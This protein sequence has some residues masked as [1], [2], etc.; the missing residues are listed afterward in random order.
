MAQMS[1][2]QTP[3][4][5]GPQGDMGPPGPP[6]P[7]SNDSGTGND[8]PPSNASGVGNDPRAEAKRL[9][10]LAQI[11]ALQEEQQI[12]KKQS[13][14]A[15]ELTPRLSSNAA[16]DP[17]AELVRKIHEHHVH[18]LPTSTESSR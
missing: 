6:G 3:G 16:R 5:P 14:V 12:M 15:Q 13:A 17:R 18:P 11:R 2:M 10:L 8:G 1:R 9:Q 4:P 7:P